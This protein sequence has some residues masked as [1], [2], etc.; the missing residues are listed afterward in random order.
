MQKLNEV[1]DEALHIEVEQRRL[2]QLINLESHAI[3]LK[4]MGAEQIGRRSS[5][6][7]GSCKTRDPTPRGQVVQAS[8]KRV[9]LEID[10]SRYVGKK[11]L[12]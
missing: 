2:A 8:V 7:S 10:N 4:C 6:N 1:W 3:A 12:C 5:K 11:I 9:V